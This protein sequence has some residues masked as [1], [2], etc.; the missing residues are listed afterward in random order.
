MLKVMG[1]R[2]AAGIVPENTLSG[3]SKAM[4]LCDAIE[5][6]VRCTKDGVVVLHHDR[7]LGRMTNG[8][9]II[10]K[11]T[12]SEIQKLDIYGERIPTLKEVLDFVKGKA[13][14]HIEL[15]DTKS[16]DRVIELISDY[17]GDV[18]IT[19]RYR[20]QILK[21]RESLGIP[22]GLIVLG[23]KSSTF[24]WLTKHEIEYVIIL[25]A[26]LRKRMIRKCHES[27]I[28]VYAYPY[29][30]KSTLKYGFMESIGV[31]GA[32]FNYPGKKPF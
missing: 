11:K 10:S 17:E 4:G 7:K 28:E 32:Y 8:K 24:R 25:A 23:L 9:G 26:F 29:G 16:T 5:I 12:F 2:G 3:I 20:Y 31:D 22:V 15:K 6:D 14:L 18:V 1:H 30:S 21:V 13:E 27:Q 19:S